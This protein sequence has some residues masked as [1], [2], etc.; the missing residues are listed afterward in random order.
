M[1]EIRKEDI[2]LAKETKV[3]KGFM[4]N[5]GDLLPKLKSRE[6]F[7][8]L[9]TKRVIIVVSFIIL[10]G[11]I[12][13]LSIVI[14]QQ[15]V[16]NLE[17]VNKLQTIIDKTTTNENNLKKEVTSL[18]VEVLQ[19]KSNVVQCPVCEIK[20]TIKEVYN[21]TNETKEVIEDPTLG[22]LKKRV[23]YL[24][25]LTMGCFHMNESG[26]NK[27]LREEFKLC[28]EELRKIRDILE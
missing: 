16:E 19:L 4:F 6:D 22:S 18:K 27:E 26:R 9:L 8:K 7:I 11:F 14:G 12:F 10:V 23:R 5:P 2:K 25:N 17:D 28:E 1:S 3:K 20:E 15:E 24:E 21:Q 13:I